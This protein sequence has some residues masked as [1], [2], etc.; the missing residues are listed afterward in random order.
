MLGVVEQPGVKEI[1][2]WVMLWHPR[3]LDQMLPTAPGDDAHRQAKAIALVCGR[4]PEQAALRRL[5]ALTAQS[6]KSLEVRDAIPKEEF[7]IT[8][9]PICVNGC[10]A[11]WNR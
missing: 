7:S 1:V 2:G 3:R 9:A 8:P 5:P 4:L 10:G 11:V 6:C